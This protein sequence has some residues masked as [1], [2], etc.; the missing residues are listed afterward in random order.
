[1]SI[2]IGIPENKIYDELIS[3]FNELKE[4]FDIEIY[5][6]DSSQL[7]KAYYS[8]KLDI[9]F[10]NPLN[11]S[12]H[13]GEQDS[14]IIPTRCLAFEAYTGELSIFFNKDSQQF[15]SIY[16]APKDNYEGETA[17]IILA[18]RYESFPEKVEKLSGS[19]DCE[20]KWEKA[21][22]DETAIDLSELWFDTYEYPLIMGFWVCKADFDKCDPIDLTNQLFNNTLPDEL[23]VVDE[24]KTEKYSYEREGIIH[25]KWTTDIEKSLEEML[26]ILFV[27]QK[28]P[29]IPEIK[30]YQ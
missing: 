11:F 21:N 28:I 26:Q 18:E 10:M 30:L 2:K 8:D 22:A 9:A 17:E 6:T 4:K 1:M 24:V 15:K 3:S 7:A 27:L 23:P 5:R 19:V 25:Y 16:Y 20:I 13:P 14:R 29:N 12:E